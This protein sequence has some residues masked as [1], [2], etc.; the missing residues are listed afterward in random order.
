VG[1]LIAF[2]GKLPSKDAV[3]PGN[4]RDLMAFYGAFP[5]RWQEFLHAHFGS[6]VQVAIF[7]GVSERAAA[8]WWNGEGGVN[9]G[10]VALACST[11]PTAATMLFAA[12]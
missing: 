1:S 11:I 12:E 5:I 8:K 10:K 9:G 3:Q 2:G 7:F 4:A 6:E